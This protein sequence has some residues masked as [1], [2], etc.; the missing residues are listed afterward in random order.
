MNRRMRGGRRPT[1]T[2]KENLAPTAVQTPER[3]ARKESLY[4][5]PTDH[6]KSEVEVNEYVEQTE[7]ICIK[8]LTQNSPYWNLRC[9]CPNAWKYH[10]YIQL[11]RN[12][13]T[14]GHYLNICVL[15]VCDTVPCSLV[16]NCRIVII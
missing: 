7:D 2:V 3:P 13:H 16:P 10:P 11:W 5:L 14:S 12:I 6:P 8:L 1:W 4:R 15:V 9:F